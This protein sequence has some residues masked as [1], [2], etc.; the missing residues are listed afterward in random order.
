MTSKQQTT[1]LTQDELKRLAKDP[2]N[3]VYQ[4]T[5]DTP[6]QLFTAKDRELLMKEIRQAYV[7]IRTTKPDLNDE[8]LRELLYSTKEKW[9]LF[10]DNHA[11]IFATLTSRE[12]PDDHI[13]HLRYM[14]YLKVQ[15]ESGNLA[16][17]LAQSMLQDYLVDKLKTGESLADYKKRMKKEE[18]EEKS[19]KKYS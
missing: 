17:H 9:K 12:T 6:T 16:P 13:M 15:E 1:Y 11:K 8:Q 7:E 18:G 19:K 4:Y 10:A 14:A 3:R 2:R 5:Y